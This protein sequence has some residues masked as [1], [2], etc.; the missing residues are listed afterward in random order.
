MPNTSVKPVIRPLSKILENLEEDLHLALKQW[1]SVNN[2]ALRDLRIVRSHQQKGSSIHEATTHLLIES[3]NTLRGSEADVTKL[4]GHARK[5]AEGAQLLDKHYYQRIKLELL[6]ENIEMSGLTKRLTS[7]RK[8]LAEIISR[9]EVEARIPHQVVQLRH[10]G[11][12]TYHTLI[13]VNSIQKNVFDLLSDSQGSSLIEL[14]GPGGIGKSALLD[15]LLRDLISEDTWD[16]VVLIDAQQ[17][18]LTLGGHLRESGHPIL[19]RETLLESLF[20]RLFPYTRQPDSLS[21]ALSLIKHRL[22]EF[23]CLI[24]IDGIELAE[25]ITEILSTLERLVNPSKVIFTT[26]ESITRALIPLVSIKLEELDRQHLPLLVQ[27]LAQVYKWKHIQELSHHHWDLIYDQVGGNPLAIGLVAGQIE[28]CGVEQ[29]LSDLREVGGHPYRNLFSHIY[30]L[31][32]RQLDQ[33]ER[34]VLLAMTF[35]HPTGGEYALLSR[36]TKLSK[37]ELSKALYKLMSLSLV[38]TGRT[39]NS[40]LYFI[41]NL[42]RSF[43]SDNVINAVEGLSQQDNDNLSQFDTFIEQ[44]IGF[45]NEQLDELD[46]AKHNFPTKEREQALHITTCAL[47]LSSRETKTWIPTRSLLLRLGS[48]LEHFGFHAGWIP[49][50]KQAIKISKINSDQQGE[51]NLQTHL[52][53]FLR[54]TGRYEEALT[55]LHEATQLFTALADVGNLAEVLTQSAHIHC[56]HRQHTKTKPLIQQVLT[57]LAETD[58]RR[59]YI[60]YVQGLLA[61]NEND[62]IAAERFFMQSFLICESQND[63]RKMAGRLGNLG[64][65]LYR[66]NQPDQSNNYYYRSIQL[67]AEVQDDTQKAMMMIGVGIVHLMRGELD[68][69]LR[70]FEAAEP[71]LRQAHEVLH[72]A[73]ANVNLGITLRKLQRW[74]EA[75]ERFTAAIT[76][77]KQLNDTH[78]T[79]NAYYELALLYCDQNKIEEAKLALLNALT[80]LDQN[81][82]NPGKA[83]LKEQITVALNQLGIIEETTPTI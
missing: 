9:A 46:V 35:L 43:L 63:K 27:E 56:I 51:A 7:A 74:V 10:L 80:N 47:K 49:Y 65:A 82:P 37:G 57:L 24:C 26:R 83:L 13:D 59:E 72:S 58:P 60:Y 17:T 41:H 54:I 39:A 78:R 76:S 71:I 14:V 66:Q 75:E 38:H 5:D 81:E 3:I 70:E 69:A 18:T 40:T 20:E 8:R 50:I 52:A 45:V 32:W 67:F 68:Q 61:L 21:M 23:P 31:A 28:I 62:P 53:I 16:Q 73:M 22:D 77:F 4:K 42:T 36:I 15:K 44:A 48:K 12:P 34:L 6:T 55:T 2:N 19:T 64:T 1:H 25:G 33:T 29:V 11:I 79:A 30:S